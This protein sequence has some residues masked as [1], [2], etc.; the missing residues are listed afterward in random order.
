MCGIA[1]FWE[2]LSRP[3]GELKKIARGMANALA[4][5]GPDDSGVWAD[6]QAGIALGHRRLSI[7]DLS[8]AG[9]QPMTSSTGR[10]VIVFNGEIYNHLELRTELDNSSN[11][12]AVSGV[13]GAALK[14][15]GHSD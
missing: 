7:I 12:K 13:A 10:F 14:W 6:P 15:Q 8:S 2:L 4:H 11:S 3:K 9:H 5:R 1:G